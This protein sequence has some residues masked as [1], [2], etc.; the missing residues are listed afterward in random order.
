ML[1]SNKF[2]LLLSKIIIAQCK[3]KKKLKLKSL[4]VDLVLLN[5][6]WKIGII[7]GYTKTDIGCIIFLKY[8]LSGGMLSPDA[9]SYLKLTK[10]QL[11]MLFV[12][13]P[14]VTYMLLSFKGISIYLKSNL[15][16][17]KNGALVA[18]L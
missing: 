3:K 6:L 7:Y 12:L 13:N 5:I 8:S 10:K 2:K 17:Q 16:K 9:F 11:N 15:I 18:K 14:N 4:S 1:T